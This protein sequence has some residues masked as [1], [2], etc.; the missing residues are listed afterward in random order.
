MALV[1][2]HNAVLDAV[3]ATLNADTDLTAVLDASGNAATRTFTKRKKAWHK[4]DTWLP[5]AWVAFDR[6]GGSKYHET[7]ITEVV[8]PA[9]IAIV[10][11]SDAKLTGDTAIIQHVGTV[12]RIESIFDYKSH[13]HMP[14]PIRALDSTFSGADLMTVQKTD[15]EYSVVYENEAFKKGFDVSIV[16][17][18]IYA[19]VPRRNSSTLGA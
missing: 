19:N 10:D 15:V 1:S 4:G 14:A 9:I 17:V 6:R 16:I 13:G 7:T 18:R 11:P 2:R 8:F 5:G 3:C 12:E